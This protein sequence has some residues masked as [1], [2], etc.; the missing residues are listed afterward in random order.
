MKNILSQKSINYFLIFVSFFLLAIIFTYPLILNF[1]NAISGWH[2]MNDGELFLWNFWWVKYAIFDLKTNPFYTNYL[3][4]PQEVSL[5]LHTLTLFPAFISSFFQIF[6]KNIVFVYN[7]MF[8]F[9][10][11]LSGLGTY[12]L[13]NYLYKN[14][15]V[16]YIAGVTFAF[17]PYVF[18]HA[19]SGHFNLMNTWTLPFYLYFFLRMLDKKRILDM[20]LTSLIIII[21]I[22]TDFHY[23]FFMFIFSLIIF[24]YYI[25]IDKKDIKVHLKNA[26]LLVVLVSVFSIPILIPTYKFSK[27]HNEFQKEIADYK[28]AVKY[29][30]LMHYFPG[31]NYQNK[32]FIQDDKRDL[33]EKNFEGGIRENNIF[34]G[35]TIIILAIL[36]IFFIRDNKKWLFLLIA[37][38]F[39][40]ISFGL[41]LKY[42]QKE[43]STIKPPAYYLTKYIFKKSDLVY[44][45]FAI[46]TELMLVILASGFLVYLSKNNKK[47][48]QIIIPISIILIILE[49]NTIPITLTEYKQ[50]DYLKDISKD[51][52]EYRII[53]LPNNL[54]YQTIIEKPQL[55]G[56]LGRRAYDLY[57]NSGPY[58]N[59]LGI[60]LFYSI[61]NPS[62]TANN[63]DKD[64][65]LVKS[66]F[67]KY[68]IKYVLIKKSF[69]PLPEVTKLREVAE[70][71]LKLHISY[72]DED[73]VV[74]KTL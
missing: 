46:V 48:A 45:R 38:V 35:Y 5:T 28:P 9:T 42:N 65:V 31:P 27:K 22:Y 3:F 37:L 10:F 24:V 30:D 26:L 40:F 17:C 32:L 7:I 57:M 64:S 11:A 49:Y 36:G 20:L 55:A 70:D 58:D 51:I 68:N 41:V 34:F 39:L 59:I 52:Q 33:I 72:E 15:L 23:L 47:L 18:A 66:E 14:K 73:I 2:R 50:N 12:L 21:Q 63:E 54:F 29:T 74:Y 44:S 6:T 43:I 60:R 4:Y 16:A 53:T 67:E 13:V 69:I 71:V 8:L 1:S 56:V 62:I 19:Y 61:N 25:Y